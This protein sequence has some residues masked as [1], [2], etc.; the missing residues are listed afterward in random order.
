[1]PEPSIPNFLELLGTSRLLTNAQLERL[2]TQLGSKPLTAE[3]LAQILVRQEHLTE[4]QARQLLKGQAG[5]VLNHYRLLNPIGRGG[6]GHVFR[7]LD[8]KTNNVVAVKVMARKLTSNQTLVSRFRR[9]IRASSKLDSPYVVRTLDA[10]RVG[11]VDFMVMEY[12]NGDQLD[13]I[14]NRIGRVPVGL[15]CGIVRD[16]AEGLQHAHR[17]KMVHRDIKPANIMVHWDDAGRGTTKLMDMGLV[18]MMADEDQEQSVTRAGQVMGTPDFMSPEQGWDTTK[19]DIRSDIYSLGCTLFRLLTGKIPFTGSNPLQVL[20]Q[21]LQRDAPSVLTVCDDVPQAVA[22]IVQKMTMRDPDERYQTPAEVAAALEGVSEPLLRS[23]FQQAAQA[24][25][26]DPNADISEPR[27]DEDVDEGDVSYR[28]FLAEVENGSSVDLML[29]TD[30]NIDVNSATLPAM[31]LNVET[32]SLATRR[33]RPKQKR[34]KKAGLAAMIVSILVIAL[35]GAFILTKDDRGP[36]LATNRVNHIPPTASPTG[37][38]LDVSPPP[39]NPGEQWSFT[40]DAQIDPAAADVQFRLDESGLDGLSID[41]A[42]GQLAWDVPAQQAPGAYH[43]IMSLVHADGDQ[44]TTLAQK[45]LTVTVMAG[46]SPIKM[47]EDRS[48]ELDV[49]APFITSVGVPPSMA[50]QHAVTYSVD[51]TMPQGLTLNPEN[52]T[53]EWRPRLQDTGKHEVTIAVAAAD[54]SKPLDQQ[55]LTLLVVPKSIEHVLPALP[56]QT[57]AAGAEFRYVFPQVASTLRPRMQTRR[58]ISPADGAPEGVTVSSDGRELVWNIPSDTTG[59]FGIPLKVSWRTPGDS[60]TLELEGTAVLTVDVA[61]ATPSKP[62]NTMPDDA[63]LALALEE[64]RTTY[65]SRLAT[66]RTMAQ[67]TALA[68]ELLELS[69]EAKAGPGDAALLQVIDEDLASRARAV[70]VQFDVAHIRATRYGVLETSVTENIVSRFRRSVM[71]ADQ[72]D[73]A[74]EHGLRLAQL[75]VRQDNLE[76]TDSLLSMVA[77]LLRNSSGQGAAAMLSSDV[78]AAGKLT[79]ELSKAGE[80]AVDAIK[81]Q[82]L[83]RLLARWQFD[84]IFQSGQG[85]NFFTV[86][87]TGT[88]PLNGREFWEIKPNL[89]ELDGTTQQAA[90]GFLQPTGGSDRYVVRMELLPATNSAQFVFGAT[91]TGQADFHAFA[92]ILDAT[93]PGRIIDIRNRA[94]MAEPSAT[95]LHTDRANLAEV[96]VDGTNVVVRLNGMPVSQGTIEKLTPGRI[97]IAANLGTP[98]PAAAIR[99]IR[100]LKLPATP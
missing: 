62:L 64:V 27:S 80:G 34:G 46:A 9:E 30:A 68:R 50:S 4:W 60:G 54:S 14:A 44:E 29:T 83:K 39:A 63:A 7:G 76:L 91:G 100:M 1:M 26:N 43:L 13:R 53:V 41:S 5:F 2:K 90:I 52:G 61:P 25:T 71:S 84:S 75:T 19:V 8:V 93:A 69:W 85:L 67:R 22:D 59:T 88:S 10:G 45:E 32:E 31:D 15:A 28:Q 40:P 99:N 55:T 70:D 78:A 96:V 82:E 51:G 73:R 33:V 66:A 21:R 16:V 36:S 42:T 89:I 81:L 49:G 18:L 6:M 65:K 87:R 12:V 56:P 23:S 92:V 97:G 86:A 94:T 17:H 11:K 72:Q 57:A 20:S 35:A 47:A 98:M 37:R 95:R 3:S 58:V 74:I 24:A 38:F 48:F 77:N 79:A